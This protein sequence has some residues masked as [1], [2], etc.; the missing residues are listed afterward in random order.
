MTLK[1]ILALF[2]CLVMTA[3]FAQTNPLS[4][5]VN[6]AQSAPEASLEANFASPPPAAKARTWWHWLNG[7]IDRQGITADLE[8]MQRVGIQEAQIF[9][10]KLGLPFGGVQYLS[11]EWFELLRYAA[12]EASRLEMELS[13]HNSAGWSSSGGPWIDPEHAMQTLVHSELTVQGNQRFSAQLPMP[14]TKLNFYRDVA[15][16]AFP[17]P[18]GTTKIK[19]L[20]YKM[21]DD[22]IRDH[23][24]PDTSLVA[25]AATVHKDEIVDL[26]KHLT[27]E[28]KLTWDVP[29]GKWIILRLGHTPTG[30]TNR[31]AVTK[32]AGLECDKMSKKAVELHW[33][34]GVQP[35][36]DAVREYVGTTVTS[37]LIDSYEVGP[38]N[39]TKGFSA[40]FKRLRSYD[41]SA[42]LPALAG[43]Y[44]DS[45]EVTERF[46]W[47]FRRT[48]GDLMAE[49]YYGRFSE[50]C[51][52]NGLTFSVEP[53]WGPFDN[54]QVGA[55]GDIVMCEFWT[56]G[57][58]FFDSPKFVSSIAHL[59]G[60]SIV[61]AE[62]FTG[63][64]GWST[65]PATLKSIGDQAW[66]QG[67][68][69]FVFHS[70]VHQ[71]WNVGP[72][73]ALSYHG[74]EFNRLNTWWE[75]GKAYMDYVGRG[76]F[77]LQQGK[78]VT[79]VLAFTG[80]SSP[81]DGILLPEVKRMGYDYDLIGVN[82]LHE[83]RVED[84]HIVSA[85]GGQYLVL[86]LPDQEWMRP[87]TL[88]K[89]AEI[90]RQGGRIIGPQ[91]RK[92]PSLRGYP[93]SNDQVRTLADSIWRT[94]LIQTQSIADFLK[95]A[96]KPADFRV[97]DGDD[98]GLSFIHRRTE[99]ADIYF[100]ANG[101]Q[102]SRAISAQFR[103]AG[104]APEIWYPATGKI[105]E[106]VVWR[107]NADG[108]TTLPLS[109]ESEE[110]FFVVFKGK[111]TRD[112]LTQLNTV[113]TSTATE[114]LANLEILSAEY[115]T[116]LQEGLVDITEE[117]AKAV[118]DNQ[119]RIRATRHFCD[120]DPA[121]GYTKEFRLEYSIGEEL[122]RLTE[123]ERDSVVIIPDGVGKLT[124]LNA[125]FGKFL[126]ETKGVPGKYPVYDVSSELEKLLATGVYDITVD[127]RLVAGKQLEGGKPELRI[128]Y[129]TAGD[130]RTVIV[131]KG[132]RLKLSRDEPSH[133]MVRQEDADLLLTP[134]PLRMTYERTEGVRQEI[135]ISTVPKPIPLDAPWQL[136]F[137]PSP[138]P[139][140]EI[141]FPELTSWS[142]AEDAALRYFSGTATYS[143]TVELPANLLGPDYALELDLGSVHVIAEV[144]VNGKSVA[145]LWKRPFR[146]SLDGYLQPGKN[147]VAVKVTNLWPNRLIG[148]DQLPT[149]YTMK[150]NKIT[151][152][153]DWL[154]SSTERPTERTTF[155]SFQHWDADSEL[156]PS[157]LLGPVRLVVYRKLAV[158]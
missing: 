86:V 45:E 33:Q 110:S 9:N 43:Y 37:C 53:Y 154:T 61:G 112:H 3:S 11:E 152:W 2:A 78:S 82:K 88:R 54:M 121:M 127:D 141:A 24:L 143:S 47:D 6:A 35:I 126:P 117:V 133:R 146:T 36:V 97:A 130:V 125:A 93:T 71:P 131:P 76:Q 91:P 10:V 94:G 140:Q 132:K 16:L 38:T 60:S 138:G 98:A 134:Y 69:R 8:A 55:T 122:Y 142:I 158:K 56:G 83:L 5:A 145:T 115:G 28:G 106:P 120:C 136:S 157:G 19:G 18:R 74:T 100:I 12:A 89:L 52:Q 149:D 102:E 34:K 155:P 116:F 148:D 20:D 103:V 84:G 123:M 95:S 104:K 75:Q 62:S 85:G 118:A 153:P 63:I 113:V 22:R 108:T 129:R 31:P 39:W 44:V 23:V 137:S 59:N 124:I 15:V 25:G 13:F 1:S 58:P 147:T 30:A 99:E 32:G 29:P 77:L 107:A 109:L 67:I 7:N 42:Y 4:K 119:L 151:A 27:E 46:L 150:M 90:A 114:P 51:H 135:E 21:L 72:G 57:Y 156:Q 80:E 101:R 50:L 92:S 73:L 49:N 111:A 68:N 41:L 79:D 81:N 96:G 139:A 64:G 40:E 26:R 70:Y 17:K 87:E 14:E 66:A 128:T 65:H 144:E 105:V 48:I